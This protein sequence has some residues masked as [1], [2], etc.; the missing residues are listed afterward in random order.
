MIAFF[1]Y[2]ISLLKNGLTTFLLGSVFMPILLVFYMDY[3]APSPADYEMDK[4]KYTVNIIDNDKSEFSKSLIMILN[5]KDFKSLINISE[6]EKTDYLITIPKDCQ[7]AIEQGSELNITV[8]IEKKAS[9]IYAG[10]LSNII[11]NISQSFSKNYLISKEITKISQT[12][13][14]KAK[15]INEEYIKTQMEVAKPVEPIETLTGGIILSSKAEKAITYI[16]FL[17]FTFLMEPIQRDIKKK[18]KGFKMRMYSLALSPAYIFAG[19]ALVIATKAFIA[20]S[21]YILILRIMNIAFL[22]NPLILLL[23]VIIFAFICGSI[24][25]FLMCFKNK[26]LVSGIVMILFFATTIF[27]V[28]LSGTM[29]NTKLAFLVNFNPTAFLYNPIMQATMGS[30][31]FEV[32]KSFGILFIMGLFFFVLGIVITSLKKDRAN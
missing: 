14:D 6:E 8:K 20:T 28:M 31:S 23:Y 19:S 7:K 26:D 12:D 15:K 10:Y 3:V 4:P 30:S 5:S 16:L 11:M 29:E 24:S 2:A 27:G 1:K 17:F 32:I 22:I 9:E 25:E 18:A 21:L 13:I